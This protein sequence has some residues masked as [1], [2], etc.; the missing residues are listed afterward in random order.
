MIFLTQKDLLH[1]ATDINF[2]S[3]TENGGVVF[4]QFFHAEY[5]SEVRMWFSLAVKTSSSCP[6]MMDEL[7]L[8]SDFY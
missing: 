6:S 2:S 1:R 5:E 4:T 7:T 8:A 3:A